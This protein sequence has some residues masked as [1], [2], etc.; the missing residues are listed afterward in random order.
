MKVL[1]AVYGE[2]V[3]DILAK[4]K[5]QDGSMKALCK[6]D[7]G[8]KKFWAKIH[9]GVDNNEYLMSCGHRHYICEQEAR[10]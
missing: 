6:K 4:I 3:V 2:S 5:L 8:D 10:K 9:R 1:V 7:D